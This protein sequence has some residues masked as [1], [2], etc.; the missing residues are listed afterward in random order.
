MG[1]S[2]TFSDDLR[3]WAGVQTRFV[4]RRSCPA[5]SCRRIIQP[6]RFI[7][8]LRPAHC[9]PEAL[10][11]PT[12]GSAAAADGTR[13]ASSSSAHQPVKCL[14]WVTPTRALRSVLGDPQH[15]GQKF[16]EVVALSP[17]TG[18][19]PAA[20]PASQLPVVGG[21]SAARR[22]CRSLVAAPSRLLPV[23]PVVQFGRQGA[24]FSATT[25]RSRRQGST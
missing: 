14:F 4:V 11:S 12:Q 20:T 13:A 10:M 8:L 5:P 23:T 25:P 1:S 24:W 3:A 19:V 6:A 16:D 7:C 18:V 9:A 17:S 2:G 21:L 15:E 22:L